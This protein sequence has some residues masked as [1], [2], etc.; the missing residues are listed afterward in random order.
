[1][2]RVHSQ[3][4]GMMSGV[5]LLEYLDLPTIPDEWLPS[6]EEI[7]QLPSYSP[8]AL[9]ELNLYYLRQLTDERIIKLLQP[10]FDFNIT[11]HIFYQYIGKD[12]G[13]H[14]DFGRK[15]AH[16]YIIEL[17]GDNVITK[18]YDENDQVIEQHIIEKKRW[19]KLI[20]DVKHNAENITS[21]RYAISIHR[22][23]N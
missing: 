6:L 8:P 5:L 19:H 21:D 18:W 3:G 1:M 17:G 4:N 9:E 13:I 10:H 11:G 15:T 2:Q 20:V 14:T 23:G 16:N 7:K 12:L 22:I